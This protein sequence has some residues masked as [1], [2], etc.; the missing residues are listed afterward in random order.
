MKLCYEYTAILATILIFHV[1]LLLF[2][3][4]IIVA[5]E[6]FVYLQSNLIYMHQTDTDEILLFYINISLM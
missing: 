4:C 3:Y 1:F 6:Y 2:Q 5:I